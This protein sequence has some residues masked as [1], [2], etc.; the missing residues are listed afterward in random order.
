MTVKDAVVKRFEQLA[1]NEEFGPTNWPIFPG[2]RRPQSTVCLTLLASGFPLLLLRSY[3]T[4]LRSHLANF[5]P[6][7]F[8]MT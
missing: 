3:V 7:R 2:S 6:A 5:S 1:I 8:L 4:V